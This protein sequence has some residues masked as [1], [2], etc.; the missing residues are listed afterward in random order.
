MSASWRPIHLPTAAAHEW[1]R[2]RAHAAL[3]GWA[4]EWVSGFTPEDP[5]LAELQVHAAGDFAGLEKYEYDGVDT[6][7]G[8]LWFRRGAPDRLAC[9]RAVAGGELLPRSVCA[10]E[11][12][13]GITAQAWKLRNRELAAALLGAREPEVFDSAA[14]PPGS[15]FA[16][17]AGAVYLSCDAFGLHALADAAVWRPYTPRAPAHPRRPAPTALDRAASQAR[18]GLAVMLGSVD[19]DLPKFLDLRRGDVLRLPQRLD[20]GLA[21][22]CDGRPLARGLLGEHRGRKCVQI[23]VQPT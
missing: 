19:I 12:V 22:T 11:W 23:I 5:R 3:A 8:A 7:A 17:G 14:A 15:L 6:G 4:R 1:L 21:V 16:F 9:S 2:R 10:D 18:V 13:A 20:Q